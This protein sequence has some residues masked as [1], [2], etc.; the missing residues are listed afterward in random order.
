MQV[1]EVNAVEPV[2]PRAM[3]SDPVTSLLER[4]MG[5]SV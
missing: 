2:P 5:F 1:L 3:A 4:L